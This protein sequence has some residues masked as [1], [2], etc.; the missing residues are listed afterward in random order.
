MLGGLEQLI[1]HCRS[2]NKSTKQQLVLP[3]RLDITE[4]V[5]EGI[6][7]F[8]ARYKCMNCGVVNHYLIQNPEE[9]ISEF[10]H[11]KKFSYQ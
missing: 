7:Q 9:L 10:G 11:K 3:D 6:N 8:D 5:D 4:M 2:C 1:H